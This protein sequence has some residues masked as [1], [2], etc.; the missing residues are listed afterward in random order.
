MLCLDD[1]PF[2]FPVVESPSLNFFFLQAMLLL[3]LCQGG[4]ELYLG[5][6]ATPSLV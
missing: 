2:F 5:S 4:L 6:G 3:R 1:G